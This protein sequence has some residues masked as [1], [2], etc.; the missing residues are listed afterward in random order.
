MYDAIHMFNTYV[1]FRFLLIIMRNL[2]IR[3]RILAIDL[4]IINLS[5]Y[6]NLNL[7]QNLIPSHVIICHQPHPH[8]FVSYL[9]MSYLILSPLNLSGVVLSYIILSCRK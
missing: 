5:L 2:R 8:P 9:I 1:H 4:S 7:H 6:L 3:A